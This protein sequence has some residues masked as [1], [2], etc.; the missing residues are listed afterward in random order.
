MIEYVRTSRPCRRAGE[1]KAQGLTSHQVTWEGVVSTPKE[2][3]AATG[4]CSTIIVLESWGLLERV[5]RNNNND[6]SNSSFEYAMQTLCM[7][8]LI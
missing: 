8:C 4:K 1:G 6:N 5:L 7:H 3:D 2:R